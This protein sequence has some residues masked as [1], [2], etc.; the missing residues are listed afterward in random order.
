LQAATER[1]SRHDTREVRMF[2][3]WMLMISQEMQRFPGMGWP[4]VRTALEGPLVI[5]RRFGLR[6]LRW[7]LEDEWRWPT[8]ADDVLDFM[9]RSDPDQQTRAWAT[10]ILELRQSPGRVSTP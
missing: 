3:W 8:D 7:F 5:E 9:A 1:L 6:N 4:L 2:P 10:D